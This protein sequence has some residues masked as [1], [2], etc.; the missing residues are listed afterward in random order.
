MTRAEH[1]KDWTWED[2]GGGVMRWTLGGF[3]IGG[4]AGGDPV[5]GGR[6]FVS[7]L[8]NEHENAVE[9]PNPEA[10][11]HAV[12]SMLVEMAFE[13]EPNEVLALTEWMAAN[14]EDADCADAAMAMLCDPNVVTRFGGGAAP[15]SSVRRC[16]VKG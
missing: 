15:L 4:P 2:T 14:E 12:T 16:S 8:A 11:R 9:F 5:E 7:H 13:G 10:A 6:C 1:A 3:V